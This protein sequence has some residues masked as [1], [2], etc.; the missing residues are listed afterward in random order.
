M[1]RNSTNLSYG[2]SQYTKFNFSM[3]FPP[4]LGIEKPLF[5]L[6]KAY[7]QF[8]QVSLVKEVNLL[9]IPHSS[10]KLA[11][12]FNK[13]TFQALNAAA[14]LLVSGHVDNLGEGVAVA[15]ATLESGKAVKTLDSWIDISNNSKVSPFCSLGL[16]CVTGQNMEVFTISFLLTASFSNAITLQTFSQ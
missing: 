10:K 8:Y 6:L 16:G 3:L 7:K 13:K 12:D 5:K 2:F 14:A 9:S 4:T 1:G 15:R 11:F